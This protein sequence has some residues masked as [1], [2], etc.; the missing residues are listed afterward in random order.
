MAGPGHSRLIATRAN[1]QLAFGHYRLDGTT[2][3]YLAHSLDILTLRDH[4]IA[5]ITAFV[6]PGLFGRFK[7]SSY[8]EA[9]QGL[10]R[11]KTM[12][13]ILLFSIQFTLSLA[14]YALI[15]LWYVVP[16]LS[17]KPRETA[18][19]PLVWVHAF[20]M[21]GGT[22]LAPGAVGIGI[23]I[24][25]QKMI[26]YGD[27]ITAFL[28]LLALAAL[29]TRSSWAI[30]LV[31]LV[32]VVGMLDTINA[33]IQ[34][35]RYDV[36][37]HA[38][39]VNWVIVTIYVPA[40]LVSSALILWQLARS[41]VPRTLEQAVAA[42]AM[43]VGTPDEVGEQVARL[44][45]ETGVE[46]VVFVA[47]GGAVEGARMIETIRLFGEHVIPAMAGREP[48]TAEVAPAPG[49]NGPAEPLPVRSRAL[50]PGQ[51]RGLK[52]QVAAFGQ[53]GRAPGRVEVIRGR[54][55]GVAGQFVH[56]GPGG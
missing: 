9:L 27:L 46:Y 47:C 26:G 29:R 18:L 4:R 30:S 28:A 31:W 37:T 53:A 38:L 35:M 55:V 40:L 24:L 16:R 17:K 33:I 1:G 32:V 11:Q 44:R 54:R 41:P 20:R 14:A 34:S 5:E 6:L 10:V 2:G 22:V 50:V 21:I 52:R 7:L 12:K 39:G 49:P 3:R 36:F 8:L 25:F 56:M 19:Q 51:P 13:P 23:P 15:G 45:D 48:A 42:G 43:L